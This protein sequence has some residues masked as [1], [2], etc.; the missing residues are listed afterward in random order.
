MI[1]GWKIHILMA[2]SLILTMNLNFAF[3][4]FPQSSR[5]SEVVQVVDRVGK[6]VVN[7]S[8]E[9]RV[10]NIF[11]DSF[12]ERFFSD[13]FDGREESEEFIQN[14]L[15]SGVII[16]P[17]G[18]ILTNEHVTLGASRIRISLSDKRTFFADVVGTDPSSDLAV[19]KIKSKEPLPYLKL[20]RSDD[21]MIGETVIA[22]GNPFG[23]SSTVTTG[24]ISALRRTLKGRASE[25]SYTDFIQIDAAINPG[26]SG[27]ALL[28][29]DGEL[30]GIN[31]AIISQAEGIGFSIPIDR[32]KKV[33]NELVFYGEV[34][35]LWL[36]MEVV[37]LDADLKRYVK[38]SKAKGAIA[39][40]VY[41]PSPAQKA[42]I[43]AGDVVTSVEGQEVESKEE[44]DTILSKFQI[45]DTI[46]IV[47]SGKGGTKTS[48]IKI[49]DF[50]FGKFSFD[51]LGM[52]V[53]DKGSS[54]LGAIVGSRT[55]GVQITKIRTSGPADRIGL[56]RGDI[57]VQINNQRISRVD[58]YNK[59][60]P[61]LLSKRSVFM[62]IIRGRY[63]Y[64]LTM[65]LN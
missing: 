29:I 36:G 3:Y 14:S 26:N 51:K 52:E 44:F 22:I 30:I 43:R 50:P 15:G 56:E 49:A 24:V 13:F 63:M 4:P 16:D 42:G 35:P 28:N 20:G 59:L 62:K 23:F 64:P 5:R 48:L 38:T 65:E 46:R 12:L 19:L 54:L 9:Q 2:L 57:I 6:A 58:D 41:D 61:T 10:N 21:I 32:A 7:I 11:Y 8:T 39:V 34:R 27:G 25:R 45:G 33:F 40:N 17:K 1:K 37:T 60:L 18:Y 53:S 31:T 55:K 47:S